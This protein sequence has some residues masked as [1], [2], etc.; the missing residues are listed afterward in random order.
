M[1]NVRAVVDTNVWLNYLFFN[2]S[3][4]I[5]TV[6]FLFSED[7]TVIA[8]SQTLNEAYDVLCRERLSRV[9]P[10][11]LR[12]AFYFEIGQISQ[13]ITPTSTVTAC[14]DP[15]DNMFLEA[16]LDG[17]ADYLISRDNDLLALAAEPHRE[18]K[19]RIVTPADFLRAI[20]TP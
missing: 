5:Q 7:C 15:R 17:D 12:L 8:S 20:R 4:T 16:A 1:D 13:L 2:N 3:S 19:F 9:L 11:D 18:W 10:S 6:R 14:R